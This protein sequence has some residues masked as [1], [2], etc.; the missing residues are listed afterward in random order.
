MRLNFSVTAIAA[1]ATFL[2]ATLGVQNQS[3]AQQSDDEQLTESLA[4]TRT[5]PLLGYIEDQGYL[6]IAEEI[7]SEYLTDISIRDLDRF[8]ASALV[9]YIGPSL[10]ENGSFMPPPNFHIPGEQL[11]VLSGKVFPNEE[12]RIERLFFENKEQFIVL[13]V[14]ASDTPSQGYIETC[15]L[16]ATLTA[17]GEELDGKPLLQNSE[18]RTQIEEIV[19][20]D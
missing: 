18:M 15:L 17:L 2:I 9:T 5:I 8:Y 12:C 19:N 16:L 20:G 3:F 1:T 4:Q 10:V 6:A 14:D 7:R 11:E 13:L